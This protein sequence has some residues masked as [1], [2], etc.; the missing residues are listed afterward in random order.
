MT[1]THAIP[2]QHAELRV[3]AFTGFTL[4]KHFA[5]LVDITVT[6]AE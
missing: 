3:M 5:D 1:P 6:G 2:L 4:T